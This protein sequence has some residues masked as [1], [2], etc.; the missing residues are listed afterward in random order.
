MR[1]AAREG[2]GFSSGAETAD[3]G[4]RGFCGMCDTCEPGSGP[5]KRHP[6]SIDVAHAASMEHPCRFVAAA[7][8]AGA[9][10]AAAGRSDPAA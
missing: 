1:R 7:V 2:R 8:A 3:L 5:G 4:W 9:A 10:G 6:W